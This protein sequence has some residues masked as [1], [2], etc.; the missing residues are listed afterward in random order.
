MC[1]I[2]STLMT[3]RPLLFNSMFTVVRAHFNLKTKIMRIDLYLL[4]PSFEL[5]LVVSCIK[6][7][8]KFPTLSKKKICKY[9]KVSFFKIMHKEM[10]LTKTLPQ[11]ARYS[12]NNK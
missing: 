3:I 4:F 1:E 11:I 8:F 6:N 5:L 12:K 9:L 2:S 10:L 7:Q